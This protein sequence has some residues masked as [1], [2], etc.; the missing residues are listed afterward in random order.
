MKTPITTPAC[1]MTLDQAAPF[2]PNFGKCSQP[3]ISS[4]SRIAA[5]IT[6]PVWK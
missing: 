5:M 1:V 3:N 4:G 6:E 2:N